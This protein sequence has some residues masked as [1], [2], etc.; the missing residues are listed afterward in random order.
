MFNVPELGKHFLN[1]QN[2]AGFPFVLVSSQN[3]DTPSIITSV[4]S[5]TLPH[6]LHFAGVKQD[7]NTE[8]SVTYSLS[9][10]CVVFFNV[11]QDF[12]TTA[13]RKGLR[14]VVLIR[15]E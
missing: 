10:K 7:C 13:L 1:L 3:T 9:E 14:V 2:F 6:S 8:K 11:P 12:R 5:Q 4:Y 15:E